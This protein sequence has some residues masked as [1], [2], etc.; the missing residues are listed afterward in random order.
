MLTV[1]TLLN[2]Y[3][4]RAV[5]QRAARN[6]YSPPQLAHVFARVNTVVPL[7]HIAFL[8]EFNVSQGILQVRAKEEPPSTSQPL[9]AE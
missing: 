1:E 4:L 7:T 2:I 5:A 9:N 3:L 8:R 6:T